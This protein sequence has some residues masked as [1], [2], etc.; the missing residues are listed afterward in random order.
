MGRPVRIARCGKLLAELR[1]AALLLASACGGES[2]P[3]AGT[4]CTPESAIFCRCPAGDPGEKQCDAAGVAFGEC[5]GCDDRPAVEGGASPGVGGGTAEG[6]PL[7][8]PC[9][10]GAE[11]ASGL[12]DGGYCTVTCA[13]VSDCEIYVAE[14]VPFDG[15]SLCRPVCES[16]T[17]CE[18]FGAPPSLCG[19][20]PAVDNWGVTVCA[21]WGAQHEL[22][23][24]DSDCA[25]FEHG[26]CNLGYAH[27]AHVCTVEGLCAD[28]C[29]GSIDCPEEESCSSDGSTLGACN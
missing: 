2:G 5:E 26:D 22:V 25:P 6:L 24:N 13:K 20:A 7:Y 1:V 15:T 27:R 21:S 29:F 14:C 9:S 19:F 12:C 11:C 8:R 3:V 18:P 4:L 16:A 10:D 23:P 17:D 28:G